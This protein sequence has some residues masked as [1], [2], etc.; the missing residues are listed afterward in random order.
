MDPTGGE[1]L[2]LGGIAFALGNFV[3]GLFSDARVSKAETKVRDIEAQRAETKT[4]RD[5]ETQELKT[6]VAVLKAQ[7]QEVTKRLAEGTAQF[8]DLDA[9]YFYYRFIKSRPW[10]LH[11]RKYFFDE[12]I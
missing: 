7:N 11:T 5:Q 6:E 9:S 10:L 4:S 8:K 3:K 1:I 2:G 12:A